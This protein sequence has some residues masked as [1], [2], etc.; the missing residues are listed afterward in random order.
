M[1]Q[2]YIDAYM[3]CAE[4]FATLSTAKKLKVG[5]QHK[6]YNNKADP[7]ERFRPLVLY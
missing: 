3:Q 4:V 7:F 2:K 6:F 5:V 1:K